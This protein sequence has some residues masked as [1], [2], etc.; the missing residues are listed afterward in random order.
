MHRKMT[1]SK[2][3]QHL[4]TRTQA[5]PGLTPSPGCHRAQSLLLEAKWAP[6]TKSLNQIK[7]PTKRG[8]QTAS[9]HAWVTQSAPKTGT[10]VKPQWS[11]SGSRNTFLCPT[12]SKAHV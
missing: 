4:K 6:R 12:L 1:P 7:I 3:A 2:A 5:L 10:E 8:T 9:P 11:S